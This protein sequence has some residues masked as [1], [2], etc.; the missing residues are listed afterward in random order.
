MTV[1]LQAREGNSFL[2]VPS[3]FSLYQYYLSSLNSIFRFRLSNSLLSFFLYHAHS[4]TFTFFTYIISLYTKCTL[5]YIHF[6]SVRYSITPCDLQH[7]LALLFGAM[8]TK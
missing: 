5:V 2:F 7:N 1:F 6:L 4:F 8:S 3:F